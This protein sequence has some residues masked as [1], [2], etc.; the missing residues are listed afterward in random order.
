MWSTEEVENGGR[1]YF[2]VT[3]SNLQSKSL[4]ASITKLT[5][6][7]QPLKWLSPINLSDA[8]TKGVGG[9]MDHGMPKTF[10]TFKIQL[11]QTLP[12]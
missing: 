1:C 2:T 9:E 11:Q 8:V 10:L 5:T 12:P 7:Y 4:K 3:S 6:V